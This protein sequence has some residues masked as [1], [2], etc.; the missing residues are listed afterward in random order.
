MRRRGE[1]GQTIIMVAYGLTLLMLAA[2]L[3]IDMGYL[4]YQMRRQ[5]T[6]A[7]SAA[8]AGAAEINFGDVTQAAQ[9]D[10]SINGYTNG[11]N[12]VTLSPGNYGS[13]TINGAS[14]T[15]TLGA[16]TYGNIV[17]NST[18]TLTVNPGQFSSIT[19]NGTPNEIFNP[20]LYVISSGNLVFNGTNTL[21]D[22]YSSLANGSPIKTAT[23]GE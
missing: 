23:L 17:L 2:G 9:T 16:G 13:V 20:G 4:R 22:N 14:N 21:N 11:S 5:Q 12:N 6:A 3:G 7:D 19:G 10:A 18:G 15:V 1:E 8:I